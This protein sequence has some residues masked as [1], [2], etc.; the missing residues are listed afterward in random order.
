MID[1]NKQTFDDAKIARL[2]LAYIERT[3]MKQDIW[4]HTILSRVDPR[5]PH[6][7][8]L[9]LGELPIVSSYLSL[10]SWSILTSRMVV[11]KYLTQTIKVATRDIQSVDFGLFKEDSVGVMTLSTVDSERMRLEY[12]AG[13]ASMAAIHY[14]QFWQRKVPY[15]HL[16]KG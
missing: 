2:C 4:A 9:E 8:Q 11:G 5:I 13:A 10:T 14:F 15:L 6:Q 12:E 7:Y 1:N 16:L 3:S